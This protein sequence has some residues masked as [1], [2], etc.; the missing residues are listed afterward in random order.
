MEI[1][2]AVAKI[3]EVLQHSGLDIDEQRATLKA[4]DAIVAT[5]GDSVG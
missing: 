4:T 3:L 5:K 1:I 2:E